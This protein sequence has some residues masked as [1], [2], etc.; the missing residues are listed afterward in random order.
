M[1]IRICKHCKNEF[2]ILNHPNGWMANHSRW[3]EKNPKRKDY[4]VNLS[5]AREAKKNFK[6]QYSYGAVCSEETKQKLRNG[7]KG[8]KHSEE[9]KQ[10]MREKALASPHRRLRKGMVEYNGIM[11]DSSWELELAK[12]LDKLEIKWIRPEPILWIDEE[13]I[14]H[15]YFGDF[16]LI[17]Y[18]LYLDPK[19]PQ[20]IKVQR[21]K[22]DC[23]LS[24]YSNIVIIESLDDCKNF[25]L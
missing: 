19:N 3:C 17:E 2:D 25:T 23:L 5:K 20:A 13:G 9:T 11:L 1:N 21:K 22:L 16:Y 14:N 15:N 12:R 8:R 10:L 4:S 7:F 6:N 18:N 24:Q